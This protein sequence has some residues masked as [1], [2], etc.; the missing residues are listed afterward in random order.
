MTDK[1]KGMYVCTRCNIEYIPEHELVRSKNK[2]E[3]PGPKTD[4]QGNIIEES[5]AVYVSYPPE[6]TIGKT[7]VEVKGSFKV[8]KDRGIKITN[9]RGDWGK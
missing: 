8:L 3:M 4:E 9:Y 2:L 5:D 1:E 7:P 6:Y